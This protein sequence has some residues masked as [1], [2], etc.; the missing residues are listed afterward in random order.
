LR[1]PFISSDEYIG[2]IYIVLLGIQVLMH[3]KLM[4]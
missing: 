1:V 2:Q 4:H 3:K